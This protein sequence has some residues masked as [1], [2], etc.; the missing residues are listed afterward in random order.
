[1]TNSTLVQ[2]SLSSQAKRLQM[3]LKA[4]IC[5]V[6][7]QSPD[8]AQHW[9]SGRVA[10]GFGHGTGRSHDDMHAPQGAGILCQEHLLFVEYAAN[11]HVLC[12][13]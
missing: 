11:L 5:L 2:V 4:S 10:R 12:V 1:M 3:D 13:S 8:S 7:S 9:R 6:D